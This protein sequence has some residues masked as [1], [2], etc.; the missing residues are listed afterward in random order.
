MGTSVNAGR[1][2][3][4][5]AAGVIA[6]ATDQAIEAELHTLLDGNGV[7]LFFTRVPFADRFDLSTLG[8]VAE[9]LEGGARTLPPGDA[10]DVLVYGCTSGTVAAG[11]PMIA[12]R[13]ATH[14]PGK[15][16]TN[17]LT[18][19]KAAL[20]FLSARRIGLLTPYPHDVHAAVVG[21]LAAEFELVRTHCLGIDVDG[22]ISWVSPDAILDASRPL[23]SN[24]DALFLSCTSLRLARSIDRF[25]AELGVPVVTSNQA[26]AWH[27][28]HLVGLEPRMRFGTLMHDPRVARRSQPTE[29]SR[30][31]R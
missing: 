19:A 18:A 31:G 9:H 16:S 25:E 30:L 28:L 4:T 22:E 21:A 15:R 8:A 26:L 11:E 6:L 5:A 29:E 23:A 24:V 2:G 10:V 27:I 17:P 20:R 12:E 1:V 3:G 13:L 7:S 14:R